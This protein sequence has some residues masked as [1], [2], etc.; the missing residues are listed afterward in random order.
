[1]LLYTQSE[2]HPGNAL[3]GMTSHFTALADQTAVGTE[4]H[5]TVFV[6]WTSGLPLML[7]QPPKT[8]DYYANFKHNIIP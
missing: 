7:Q 8:V 1:M 2:T 5:V 6:L 4:Y 3:S